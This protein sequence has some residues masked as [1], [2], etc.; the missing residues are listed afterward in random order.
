MEYKLINWLFILL[1]IFEFKSICFYFVNFVKR[2]MFYLKWN[3]FKICEFFKI[4]VILVIFRNICVMFLSN[5]I[6]YDLLEVY[7]FER[8]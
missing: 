1:I 5:K 7:I 3:F 8:N 4:I 2:K 6:E